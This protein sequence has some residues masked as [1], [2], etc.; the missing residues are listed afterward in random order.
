MRTTIDI[1]DDMLFLAK[2]FARRD[3][4]TLGVVI[5]ELLRKAVHAPSEPT[6]SRSKGKKKMTES[7]MDRKFREMGFVTFPSRKGGGV[8]TNE[9]INRIR[10]EE[11][12]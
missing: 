7:E 10:E 12:I 2:D 11:G 8:V 5:T 9:M 6:L 3:K 4:K 1:A